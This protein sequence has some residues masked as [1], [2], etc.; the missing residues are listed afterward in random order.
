V[1][2]HGVWIGNW[3]YWRRITRQSQSQNYVTTDGYSASLSWCQAPIL[4]LRPEFCYCKTV[5]GLLIWGALSDER[6]GLSFT[7]A[8]DSRQRSHSRVR[9]PRDFWPY[10]TLSDLRHLQPGRPCSCIYIPQEQGGTVIP[11]GTGFLFRRFLWLAGLWWRYSNPALRREI[12]GLLWL[13]SLCTNHIENVFSNNVFDCCVRVRCRG[14]VFTQPL[15]SSGP[16]N[17]IIIR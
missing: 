15:P 7:V 9:N 11:P 12:H 3:I 16:Y 2:I 1:T 6:T 4:G 8:A 17:H 13:Y 10:F 5:A 14:N